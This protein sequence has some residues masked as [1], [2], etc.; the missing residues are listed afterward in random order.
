[1]SFLAF[2]LFVYLCAFHDFVSS[3]NQ[4]L[5]DTVLVELG[6]SVTLNCTYNCSSGFVRGCWITEKDGGC[7]SAE[8][9]KETVC[10]VSFSL[11]NITSKDLKEYFCKT[12]V[13]DAIPFQPKTERIV[14]LKLKDQTSN[15]I[16]HKTETTKVS[17]QSE[18]NTSGAAEKPVMKD[19]MKVVAA[20]TVTVALVLAALAVYLCL[21]RRR[22][23][24]NEHQ[25]SV[26]MSKSN[27]PK[28]SSRTMPLNKGPT[29]KQSERVMLRIPTPEM[30]GDPE[31]PYADIVINV[32]GAS[33][34]DISQALYLNSGD[35]NELWGVHPRA[36]LQA[37]RSADMLHL[38]QPLEVCRKM[39][40]T[41]DYAVITYA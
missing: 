25:S 14:Q 15:A 16:T 28:A 20:V 41:S 24:S 18:S 39:S 12:E 30:E 37:A 10:T 26:N 31:V 22:H 27:S 3:E 35:R 5:M 2:T 1:M 19:G 13:S 34:P 4:T 40:T 11:P 32:R 8:P 7:T 33:T 29:S 9:N 17:L 21:T 36:R 23:G 6:H 38:P